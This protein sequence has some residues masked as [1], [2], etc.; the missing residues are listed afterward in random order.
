[1]GLMYQPDQLVFVDE[2]S[3]DRRAV[4]RCYA[5]APKGYRVP[6]KAFFVRG[7][8]YVVYYMCNQS[9]LTTLQLFYPP[10]PVPQWY[11]L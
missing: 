9:E 1:M 11:C 5:Y 6:R 4:Y 10:C 7:Q 8:R 2:S 3:F